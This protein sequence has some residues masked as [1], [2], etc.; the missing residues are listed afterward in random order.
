MYFVLRNKAE[1]TALAISDILPE[2]LPKNVGKTTRN[3][4]NHS[5]ALKD[6]EWSVWRVHVNTTTHQT[7]AACSNPNLGVESPFE[8][9]VHLVQIAQ[10]RMS[11]SI[12]L[13]LSCQYSVS[14]GFSVGYINT[15]RV[16]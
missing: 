9:L 10:S 3:F 1:R 5:T 12:S 8:C 13:S 2:Y 16:K 7:T 14:W 6:N 11:S 4:S 15:K